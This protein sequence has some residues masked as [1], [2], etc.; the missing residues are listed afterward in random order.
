MEKITSKDAEPKLVSK[1]LV[2]ELG[3]ESRLLYF[4]N[5]I[6]MTEARI[7]QGHPYNVF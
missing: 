1:S 3:I 5:I 6:F 2:K 4:T 7:S